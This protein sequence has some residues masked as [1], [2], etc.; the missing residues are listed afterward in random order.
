M[1]RE[2]WTGKDVKGKSCRDLTE[3]PS[4]DFLGDWG[5]LENPAKIVHQWARIWTQYLLNMNY[6]RYSLGC[7]VL[8]LSPYLF[9]CGL[10][11]DTVSISDYKPLGLQHRTR[12][13]RSW[14]HWLTIPTSVWG[15][16]L[17]HDSRWPGRCSNRS[18]PEYRSVMLM[19]ESTCL[20]LSWFSYLTNSSL[21]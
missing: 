17:S 6:S 4:R 16:T 7:D 21:L 2:E 14:R 10:L 20:V 1:V 11:N 8:F 5:K 18:A 15:T 12:R 13:K 19:S 9:I 3:V